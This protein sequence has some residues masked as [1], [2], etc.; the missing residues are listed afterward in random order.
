MA[1]IAGQYLERGTLVSRYEIGEK[2]GAGGFGITY[3][4]FDT[5]LH[6]EVAIKAAAEAARLAQA[7]ADRTSAD[8][9]NLLRQAEDYFSASD[10]V[11]P[12][13]RNA[14]TAYAKV[15]AVDAE[16]TAALAGMYR[17]GMVYE[18]AARIM[19]IEGR[20]DIGR[21]ILERG[22]DAVPEHVGL[23]RLQVRLPAQ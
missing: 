9:K 18:R 10:F 20:S 2:L 22:L 3:K 7:E 23:L 15:L 17:I 12:D 11:E 14:R 8:L 16:N 21:Q 1:D 4:A 6:C 5:Q 19:F 13:G